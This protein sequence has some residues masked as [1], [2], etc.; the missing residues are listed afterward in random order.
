[1]SAKN[2]V[3]WSEGM[4][5]RPQHFQQHDRFIESRIN[6]RARGLKAHDWGFSLLEIDQQ[7]L[8]AGKLVILRACGIFSDG[9]PFNIPQDDQ[10]TL[11]LD[12]EP[13]LINTTIKLALPIF[14]HNAAEID[15]EHAPDAMARYR[16]RN[17]D[18]SDHLSDADSRYTLQTACIQP[19]L[20]LGDKEL[21]GYHC[22]NVAHVIEVSNDKAVRL[23]KEFIPVIL[24][25]SV[26]EVLSGWLQE[27]K[28]MLRVRG[29]SL[30]QSL[31]ESSSKGGAEHFI[32]LQSVNRYE[33]LIG[34][35]AAMGHAHPEDV[36]QLMLL[37]LG[38]FAIFDKKDGG[39]TRVRKRPKI[40]ADYR[41]EDLRFSFSK[42][43]EE[44]RRVLSDMLRSPAER[45]PLQ[46]HQGVYHYSD[47]QKKLPF[48]ETGR[49]ILAAKAN[50]DPS[51]LIRD[52]AG[53]AIIASGNQINDLVKAGVRG[54]DLK[55][56][57]LMPPEIPYHDGFCYFELIKSGS[58]WQ[59]L[60]QGGGIV[61][62]VAGKFPGLEL[63]LWAIQT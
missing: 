2:R 25:S 30:A 44:L 11:A 38:D 56:L 4:F 63:E 10:V 6:G 3:I 12:L 19:R 46:V 61:F 49:F 37:M 50:V 18:V 59:N 41:H 62:Y 13:G 15:S 51:Q 39:E 55:S 23:D 29:D 57:P 42:V 60:Q 1:M 48:L 43:I 33:P 26:S 28:G 36:Y 7:Q 8:L 54:V 45:V 24:Q 27:L 53:Q 16:I 9:T 31:S 20:V 35:L 17:E 5:L 21:S 14:R 47:P 22:L 40:D 52:F 58:Y 32:Y 34:H